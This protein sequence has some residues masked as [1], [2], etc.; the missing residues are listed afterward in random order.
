M[1]DKC[2]RREMP[3]RS[4]FTYYLPF[5][6]P[7]PPSPSPSLSL[8][9]PSYPRRAHTLLPKVINQRSF[10]FPFISLQKIHF[11]SLPLP[12]RFFPCNSLSLLPLSLFICVRHHFYF[13]CTSTSLYLIYLFY[14][15]SHFLNLIFF[16]ILFSCLFF[17]SSPLPFVHLHLPPAWAHHLFSRYHLASSLFFLYLTSWQWPFE[18]LQSTIPN[19]RHTSTSSS[20]SDSHHIACLSLS[21]LPLLSSIPHPLYHPFSVFQFLAKFRYTYFYIHF[22]FSSTFLQWKFYLSILSPHLFTF[23]FFL[24]LSHS[25]L[26][27][28]LPFLYFPNSH[29]SSWSIFSFFSTNNLHLFSLPFFLPP[30]KF[31]LEPKYKRKQK[32]LHLQALRIPL[33]PPISHSTPEHLMRRLREGM[34]WRL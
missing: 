28:H 10:L 33:L 5:S 3:L 2:S 22:S 20:F 6:L 13:L 30:E 19:I 23:F 17:L 25:I 14:I 16:L 12:S 31:H 26:K 8:P 24:L 1:T 32:G 7:R 4:L 27:A 18:T 15:F 29:H 21:L 9:F 34:G 11:L